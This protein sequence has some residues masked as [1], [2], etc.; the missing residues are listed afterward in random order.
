MYSGPKLSKSQVATIK[1]SVR[2]DVYGAKKETFVMEVDGNRVVMKIKS[3]FAGFPTEVYILPGKHNLIL[4][5][6]HG[7]LL[8]SQMVW[9]AVEPG[10][11]YVAKS[12]DKGYRVNF[13]LVDEETGLKVGG[14]KG[15]SDEPSPSSTK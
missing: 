4:A 12:T 9:I 6:Y 5:R 14:S 7:T 2:Q 15:S 11:T 1:S 8:A 13:F 10:K 3:T